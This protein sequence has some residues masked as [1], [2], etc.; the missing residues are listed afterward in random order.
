MGA[1]GGSRG[2]PGKGKKAAA[3]GRARTAQAKGSRTRQ[4]PHKESP[5][6]AHSEPS[7][8]AMPELLRVGAVPGSTPGKW[9]DT[10]TE[11]FPQTAL[12][13][14]AL[15]AADQ[16]RALHDGDV[17]LAIVRMPVTSDEIHVIPLYE[18]VPVVVASID[19]HLMAADDLR[20][21]DLAGEVVIVPGDDVLSL[22]VVGAA[23]PRFEPPADTAGAI[24]TVAAG[25]GCVVVPM[26]IARAHQRK[27]ADWRVLVDGPVSP[28]GVAWRKDAENPAV[29][30]F[31]GIVRGRTANSSRN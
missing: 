23:P 25:V 27:D 20:L 24:A 12:E 9:I 1:G 5:T 30:A 2:K 10:F 22:S 6:T 28:V 16:H 15:S 11:R 3:G 31:I 26:S 13:F 18:E 29:D 19:S 8:P 17:D 14:V 21:E 7:T 4:A